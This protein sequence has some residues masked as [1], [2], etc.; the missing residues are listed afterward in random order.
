MRIIILFSS[1]FLFL[2]HFTH[3]QPQSDFVQ[4]ETNKVLCIYQFLETAAQKRATIPSY[5]EL[6]YQSYQ[7]DEAFW[8]IVDTFDKLELE[9]NAK[10][11]GF[12]DNRHNYLSTEDLLWITSSNSKDIN[13]FS[14]RIIGILPHKT[15][16]KLVETLKQS[17][18][19]YD[20]MVWNKEQ[21]NIAYMESQLSQYKSEIERLFLT[22]SQFYGTQWDKKVPFKI[23][24][25]PIPTE[26]GM[27]MAIPKGNALICAFN[28]HNKDDYIG[29]LGVIIHEMCHILYLEQS[30]TKQ[31]QLDSL[32]VG[33]DSKF[34]RLAYTYIDEGLATAIGNGW[35]YKQI[36]GELDTMEWYNDAYINGFAHSIYPLVENYLDNKKSIDAAFVEQAIDLFGQKFPKALNEVALLF[37]SMN[38]YFNTETESEIK[39]VQ[40]TLHNNFQLRSYSIAAPFDDPKSIETISDPE[41]TKVFFISKDHEAAFDFLKTHTSLKQ[42][43]E[44]DQDFIYSFVDKNT[45]S[46]V[47]VV[48]IINPDKV[49]TLIQTLANIKYLEFGETIKVP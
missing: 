12:P 5:Y 7:E 48:N 19:Y 38:L 21:D 11:D 14:E 37:N 43:L 40:M 29:R 31:H 18:R 2:H 32:F 17:E 49:E 15:Q 46:P 26:R 3:A 16:V 41:Q 13:D 39:T 9:Q 23:L 30:K 4:I 22:A 42:S 20:Q 36:H 27:T 44:P 45:D 25:Y 24:L 35:A 6:I 10:R 28:A 8:Q 33:N 47:I 34:N 1:L